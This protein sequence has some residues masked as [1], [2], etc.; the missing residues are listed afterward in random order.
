MPFL[1]FHRCQQQ[2]RMK[3]SKCAAGI[4]SGRGILCTSWMLRPGGSSIPRARQKEAANGQRKSRCR[5]VSGS[6]L[7]RSHE[8]SCTIFRRRRLSLHWIRSFTNSQAKNWTRGGAQLFQKQLTTPPSAVPIDLIRAYSS[9][10]R[11]FPSTSAN[12]EHRLSGLSSR[13]T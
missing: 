13:F 8:L 6:L 2:R 9:E 11:R 5:V 3:A 1:L 7:H 4:V 10:V 12:N